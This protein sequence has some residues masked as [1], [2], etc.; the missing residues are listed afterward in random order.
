MKNKK[1]MVAVAVVA[2]IIFSTFSFSESVSGMLNPAAVYCEDLGYEY[3]IKSTPEGDYGMCR[4]P[5]GS[6]AEE[7]KFLEGKEGKE[8]S[9]CEQ[10]G[11]EIKTVS[12]GCQF[13]VECAVCVLENGEEVEVTELMELDFNE[14]V[15]GDGKCVLGESYK[16]CSEDCPSGSSD[17][18]CDGITDG[19]C[20]PD[21]EEEEDLDCET[22]MNVVL[23]SDKSCSERKVVFTD[24]ETVYIKIDSGIPVLDIWATI[25][26]PDN[27]IK[28]LFFENNSAVFQSNKIGN[29]SLW[30]NLVINIPEEG[31]QEIK[32]EKDF[33]YIEKS[34]GTSPVSICNI[35][36]KCEG[37]ENEQNCPQDCPPVA[38]DKNIKL[39]ILAIVILLIV[40]IAG[41]VIYRKKKRS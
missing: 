1:Y 4:F 38:E 27:E 21:C 17:M 18:Y 29:F 24:G 26:T 30:V 15:C 35:N 20:D 37:E 6:E 3:T 7:W 39:Y 13:S 25:K 41:F 33:S 23:C 16:T 9:Y 36:G 32:I 19:I 2:A 11:Y 14:G 8:Y 34:A 12:E 28:N 22:G 5:D 40:G 10:E 31:Y